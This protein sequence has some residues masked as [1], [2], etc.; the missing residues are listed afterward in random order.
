VKESDRLATVT[1]ELRALGATVEERADSL[2]IQPGWSDAPATVETHNDHRIAMAFAI[3]GLARG[4]VMI[5]KEQVVTKS[6]PRFWRDLS[7]VVAS[8]EA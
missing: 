3:A 2:L 4:N 7:S 8:S 1:S 6:Y 5:E